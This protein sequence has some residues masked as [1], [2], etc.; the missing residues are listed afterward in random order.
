M[1]KKIKPLSIEIPKF[2]GRI[3]AENQVHP[4][5]FTI[6]EDFENISTWGNDSILI[7][8]HDGNEVFFR[9]WKPDEKTSGVFRYSSKSVDPFGHK[10]SILYRTKLEK[11]GDVFIAS[12]YCNDPIAILGMIVGAALSLVLVIFCRSCFS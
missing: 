4:G 5:T 6:R 10:D 2:A 9:A 11:K 8:G 12:A 1:T 7:Y 3:L